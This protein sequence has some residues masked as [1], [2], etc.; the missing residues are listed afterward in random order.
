MP[1]AVPGPVVSPRLR[2]ATLTGL[3][4][5]TFVTFAGVLR[6]GWVLFDD[7]VYVFDHPVVSHGLSLR[8]ML[9]FLH[10]PH[11]ANWVPLTAW[12]HML[13]VQLFGLVPAGHHATSLLLHVFNTLLVALVLDRLT[14][15]WWRSVS[16]AACFGLHPLRVESVAWI[17]ER[18]DVL[19]TFFLLLALNA[20]AR[21][22]ERPGRGRFSLVVA[23]FGLGLMSKPMLVTL[24]FLL[25]VLDVW[26][27]GRLVTWPHGAPPGAPRGS[28]TPIP[29]GTKPLVQL[30]REKWLL[31]AM[32]VV[33]TIISYTVQQRGGALRLNEWVP[34]WR[35]ACSAALSYWRYVAMTAW[36]HDLAVFH[37]YS[38]DAHPVWATIAALGIGCATVGAVALVRRAPWVTAGWLWYAGML[39]P[40]AGILQTGHQ[41]YAD[42]FTYAPG[43]GL[44]IA[45]VWSVAAAAGRARLSRILLAIVVVVTLSIYGMAAAR[46]VQVWRNTRTLF[47]RVLVV[48]GDDPVGARL[49]YRKIGAALLEQGRTTEAVAHLERGAGLAIGYE[50]SLRRVLSG[51]DSDLETRRTLAATLVREGRVGEAIAEYHAII[52]RDSSDADAF[53]NI[54][55][56]RATHLL[57]RHRDG[58]EAVRLAERARDL[59]TQPVAVVYSTLA[60]A[61]AEAGR[62]ADAVRAGARAVAL[63]RAAGETAQAKSFARQLESYRAGRPYHFED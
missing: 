23:A 38:Q 4:A 31:I 12:S 29:T 34:L 42:R 28:K 18:K 52:A 11:G 32:S 35:R 17:A 50:D 40:V 63:A 15:A 36:P 22:V 16:V 10:E 48:S 58:N 45:T 55:W 13:D 59:C 51:H 8:G 62:Y 21:W 39:V 56:I 60:A 2:L 44:L 54:A 53:N 19:S 43:I 24:P 61:Y 26:P 3:A 14:G 20:Y 46:Q 41:A 37:G 27:M 9:E 49:A 6:N 57:A 5:A 33:V 30:L 7:D 47:E 25:V 1:P